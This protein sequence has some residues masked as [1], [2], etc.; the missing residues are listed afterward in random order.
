M[1]SWV[2]GWWRYKGKTTARE[3]RGLYGSEGRRRQKALKRMLNKG[4]NRE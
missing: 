1:K 4:N 3:K 2:P